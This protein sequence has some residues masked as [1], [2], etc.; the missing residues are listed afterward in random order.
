MIIKFFIP[1]KIT[2]VFGLLIDIQKE[3]EKQTVKY[4]VQDN[5][6]GCLYIYIY[7]EKFSIIEN[8]N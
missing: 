7:L 5:I 6:D 8:L 4:I 3:E 2:K 1:K